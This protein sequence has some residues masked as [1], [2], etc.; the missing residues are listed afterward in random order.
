[1]L[2]QAKP[3]WEAALEREL[4][5][6]EQAGIDHGRGHGIRFASVPPAEQVRLDRLYNQYALQEARHIKAFGLEGSRC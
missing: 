4:L 5:A 2:I 1:L 6:A 3:V